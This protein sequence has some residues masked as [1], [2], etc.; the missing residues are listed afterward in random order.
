MT[1]AELLAQAHGVVIKI[2]SALLVNDQ[3]GLN[4]PWLSAAPM[5]PRFLT[6]I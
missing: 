2:G 4:E 1:A 5:R 3:G 6:M